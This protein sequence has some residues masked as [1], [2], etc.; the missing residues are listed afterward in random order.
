MASDN[1]DKDERHR[2][3]ANLG[4]LLVALVLI[5]GG[6]LLARELIRISKLQDCVMAGHRNCAQIQAPPRLN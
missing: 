1:S 2:M 4:G 3:L 6:I 5:V